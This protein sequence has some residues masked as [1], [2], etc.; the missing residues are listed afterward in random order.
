LLS[1]DRQ[2]RRDSRPQGGAGRT[3]IQPLRQLRQRGLGL[4]R[5][6]RRE[7]SEH[8]RRIPT[9]GC[10]NARPTPL[11]ATARAT[12]QTSALS[13]PIALL[14]ICGR[15]TRPVS[16]ARAAPGR[17]SSSQN[18]RSCPPAMRG[19]ATGSSDC[20][21]TALGAVVQTTHYSEAGSSTLGLSME[22]PATF[23]A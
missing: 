6:E 1:R 16:S 17:R 8:P 3:C 23:F 13:T 20:F 7:V 5:D 10:R 22:R 21:T 4:C 9:I 12:D 11:G 2:V 18:I 19:M 14:P 15:S